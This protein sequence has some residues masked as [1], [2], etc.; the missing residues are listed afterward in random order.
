[1]NR[2]NFLASLAVTAGALVLP[3]VPPGWKRER[4]YSFGEGVGRVKLL[5]GELL[6]ADQFAY[7][8]H[9]ADIPL[10]F[11]TIRVT[12]KEL[13][14]MYPEHPRE[15]APAIRWESL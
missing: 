9:G 5:T 6:R 3:D 10:L 13:L 2:R 7:W 4:V 11:R 1:M 14:E 12:K 15:G 8:R